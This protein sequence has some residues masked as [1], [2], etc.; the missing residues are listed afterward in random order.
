MGPCDNSGELQ[1]SACEDCPVTR[2]LSKRVVVS[3]KIAI[4]SWLLLIGLVLA[5]GCTVMMESPPSSLISATKASAKLD[6]A[7]PVLN[8]R[9]ILLFGKITDSVAE[10]IIRKLFYLDAQSAEPIDLYLLTPGGE[11]KAAFSIE[12]TFHLIR[13]PVRTFALSECNSGGAVLLASGTGGR[14][15]FR[16]SIVVIHGM[17]VSGSPPPGFAETVQDAYT[18]FWRR[19]ARLPS[20]WL[21]LPHGVT[22]VLTAEQALEFGVIDRILE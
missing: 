20:A 5:Q 10:E 16:G 7:D 17:K 22:H 3:S 6:Y 13:S 19:R 14:A 11:L 21:P 15:A 8:Q 4:P 9:R 1:S 2:T 12:Q 18:S